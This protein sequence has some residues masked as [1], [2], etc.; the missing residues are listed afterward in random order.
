MPPLASRL[1][2]DYKL[3]VQRMPT[4]LMFK[5]KKKFRRRRKEICVFDLK[6][7]ILVVKFN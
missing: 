6:M 5:D 2:V 7:S 1:V 3:Q 4:D